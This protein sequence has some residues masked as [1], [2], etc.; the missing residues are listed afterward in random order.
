MIILKEINLLLFFYILN[1]ET[2][3]K[4]RHIKTTCSV[5]IVLTRE[6]FSIDHTRQTQFG[7][8]QA[9]T[10]T[11]KN[12]A[13]CLNTRQTQFGASQATTTTS[14]KQPPIT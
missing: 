14:K 13:I 9:I 12:D 8:S 4:I 1:I 7:A 6:Y 3:E 2:S 11:S 5:I 10:T